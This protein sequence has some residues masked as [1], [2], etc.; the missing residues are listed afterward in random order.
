MQFLLHMIILLLW[1]ISRAASSSSDQL[2]PIAKPNCETHCGDV[3]VPYPFGIGPS[4]NCY[5]YD[6]FEIE[7]DYTTIPPRPFLRLAKLEV[8]SISIDGTLRVNN[9]VTFFYGGNGIR[10][11]A[12]NLTGSPFVYS[13]RYNRLTAVSCGFFLVVR[14]DENVVGGCMSTCD[15]NYHSRRNYGC[16]GINCCQTT[17]PAYLTAITVELQAEYEEATGGNDHMGMGTGTRTGMGMDGYNYAF[18][19]EQEEFENTFSN[20]TYFQD[21]G[22][23]PVVLEWSLSLD[24]IDECKGLNNRCKIDDPATNFGDTNRCENY[25]GGHRCYSIET[26]ITCQYYGTAD[27]QCFFPTRWSLLLFPIQIILLGLG[28]SLGLLIYVY[29]GIHKRKK[30]KRKE[31]FF[32]RNGGLLLEQQLS[33]NKGNVEKIK[34][35]K[36]KELER[37]THN[38]KINRILGHGGQGTVYKGMLADGRIVAIKKSKIVDEGKLSEFINEVVILSQINH[39]NVVKILG[40]C[41]ETEVP[42][43]VYEFIPNGT[44]AEYIQGKVEEFPLT[45]AMRL[46]I[47]TEIAGALSYLHAAASFPIFH[48]DI[49]S[50]N[51]LLDE[52][53]RAK[54]ADFGTSRSVSIDQTHVTTLVNDIDECKGLNNRCKIDDPATNFG[55]TNRC[56]NYVGGHRCYSIETG[57]TCQYYGTADAQCFFP[58]RWSLLLF[59][60]QII[61]LG[62]GLS[63]GLLIYVYKGIHKRKKIKRKEM[64]FKRNGG[65]LLEQQL[66]SNKGNVEKIKLFK[67][68]ELERSTHNFKINRILGH[69]GQGT[70]YKGMLA[71]GRIVA[72]KK[73]KIV[74]EG[75]LSEFINEVV[76][77]SQINHRNVVKILGCC[78]ETE[79]PLLVYEFIP[80]GTLA[81]YIQGK[82]EEF[83]LTWAMRLR[84]ATEIAGALSYLHA[85][86]SFPIFHRDIKSTNILLDEKYRAKVADFGTSRSVSIDQTHVTTL[87]N[88]T[89]GYLDPEYFHSNRFT[90]KSDVYSFGVVLVELLTGQKPVCAVTRSQEDEYRS[91]ATHFIISMQEDC[92]FDIVDARILKEGSKTGIEVFAKL[93]GRCLNFNG[94]NRPTMR[95][96]TTELEAIQKSE[97]TYNESLEQQKKVVSIQHSQVRIC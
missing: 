29:K 45:W 54:V 34:L 66:S 77:L 31:M 78:L 58:T 26:G 82:V 44:L 12:P 60:I 24:N 1:L 88:G 73:S 20:F 75:K 61:L 92:L 41:L 11:V 53:Y 22:S 50:T 71:D 42:L 33:S 74:D 84:I 52:K 37:S 14:S 97:T 46:R 30:I 94:R 5:L 32:K 23:V 93:A 90:D 2:A 91:L 51:I 35:F 25:V 21:K 89:F 19:I 16:I 4:S 49:K 7:C 76:I 13:E 69:G 40:C 17:F 81:E 36:S 8:L 56:E 80:N 43:L 27:A 18:I 39:R 83:P 86:A 64:F 3:T 85:A 70:V 38:F 95:E 15:K 59:P 48:R 63:L 65:L 9:P 67:S 47:A 68:K 87:V 79:V 96:V 6:W 28:L 57:I 72:I 55:D 62:L 10:Q